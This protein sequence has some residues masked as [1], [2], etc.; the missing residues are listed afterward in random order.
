MSDPNIDDA[1]LLSLM[2]ELE[3]Q[4]AK[5]TLANSEAAAPTPTPVPAVATPAPES[6]PV[7]EEIAELEESL[8][9]DAE[10]PVEAVEALTK[11][12]TAIDQEEA[13]IP[14]PADTVVVEIDAAKLSTPSGPIADAVRA[15]VAANMPNRPE[16]KRPTEAVTAGANPNLDFYI[17]V[18]KFRDDTKVTEAT[19][20]ACMIE[21]NGLRAWYGA[22]AARAE[23]QAARVKAKFEVVECTLYDHHRKLLA[24][25]S[26]KVTE[27][28]VEAAVKLDSRW[29]KGKNLVIEAETI[30]SINKGLVESI[31]DRRDMIIQLGADRRDEYKGA[32]RVMAEQGQRDSMRDRAV[33]AGMQVGRQAA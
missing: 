16:P 24:A 29:L 25:G 2:A 23:A 30:A 8:G 4:N 31:K 19:L 26:E 32:A 13:T 27:K 28:M 9:A 22:Q 33:A 12:G 14:L 7:S 3:E 17:D 21:Q 18:D 11:N 15:A 5:I 6:A 10:L 1:E 20:D